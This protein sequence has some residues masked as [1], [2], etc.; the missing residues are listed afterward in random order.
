MYKPAG[1]SVLASAPK[2]YFN[3]NDLEDLREIQ[4]YIEN[5]SWR[6]CCPF[7]IEWPRSSIPE[8]LSDAVLKS[9]IKT[10]IDALKT[11]SIINEEK[12]K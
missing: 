8:Q 12:T 7:L 2:R 11:K 1:A 4:H 3:P 9:H 10:I 6:D 5:G